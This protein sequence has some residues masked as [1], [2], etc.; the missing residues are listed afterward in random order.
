MRS[1]LK[2]EV[3]FLLLL[4]YSLAAAQHAPVSFKNRSINEGLS[5]SSVVDIAFD[6]KGFVWLATQDGLNRYDG[7]E[8]FILEKK[9][10]DITSGSHSRLGKISTAGDHALWVISKGGY[11][12]KLDLITNKFEAVPIVLDDVAL[13]ITSMLPEE[14]GNIWIGTECGKLIHYESRTRKILTVVKTPATTHPPAVNVIFRDRQR[15]LWLAGSTPGYLQNNS[16]QAAVVVAETAAAPPKFFSTFAEDNSG[17]IWAGTWGQGLFVKQKGSSSFEPFHGYKTGDLPPGL[18]V[19]NLLAD[20]LGQLWVGSYGEGLFLVNDDQKKV[21]QFVADKTNPFSIPFNDVLSVKQDKAGGVWIGTDGGG[22]SYYNEAMNNFVLFGTQ[23]VPPYIDIA[24]IRSVTTD[25]KGTIWVGTSN[26]GLTRLNNAGETY[27]TWTF[28][29]FK[30]N[31]Y[32]PDRIV[33]LFNSDDNMLWLGTQGNGLIVFDPRTEKISRWYN[34]EAAAALRIPDG[35]IWCIYPGQKGDLWLGTGSSGLCLMNRENELIATYAPPDALNKTVDAIRCILALNDSTLCVGFEKT[36]IRLFNTKRSAFAS[37]NAKTLNK[38]LST[39]TTIKSIYHGDPYLYIGT[40]GSGLYVHNMVTGHGRVLT[41]QHGLPNNTIYGILPDNLGFL[42]VSTNRGISR[43]SHRLLLQDPQP[44]HFVNYTV[45]Q[46]LQ[47][48]EFNTGAYHKAPNG[49][50]LF[51]GINGLNVFNPKDF[52]SPRQQTP[53]VFTRILVDN[54]PVKEDSAAPFNQS[55]RLSHENHS[56]AFNFSALDFYAPRQHHYYYKL[57]GYD[58]TW[59]DAEER[60][61]VSYTNIS[62]GRYQFMVTSAL[63]G[64]VDEPG[65]T[66]LFVVITGPFWKS[67][68]FLLLVAAAIFLLLYAVYRSRIA[69]LLKLQQVRQGIATDLHDDIGSTLSNIHILSELSK[70][71]LGVPAQATAF[72]ERI[73][74]EVQSSSQSLDDIIWSVNSH[75]DTWP[76]TFSRMRRYASEVFENSQTAYHL[77]IEENIVSKRLVMEKRRD[78]FLI[79]KEIINNIHRHAAATEVWINM[80]FADHSLLMEIRD[81]GK[82]YDPAEVTHRNGLK[83]LRSRITHWKGNLLIRTGSDGTCVQVTI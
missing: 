58:K 28:P 68:W 70:K 21:Q 24:L 31:I 59:I 6:N 74:E 10:D 65:A 13:G 80:R 23:T 17:R 12:E 27:K 64:T 18:V 78:I 45:V 62:P 38:F 54:E 71:N 79:Y 8:F 7:K 39:G 49:T 40:D 47:S 22:L 73:S 19:E 30:K 46:G 1:Q 5:Q 42:W 57:E 29:S 63:P 66:K 72:L 53:V 4:Q 36:G 60:S 37:L 32:N 20:R 61:Y 50:L 75:N 35:T 44:A 51:G 69:Q 43:L 52:R 77:D 25:K 2:G 15:R 26:K 48:N 83:N 3:L 76:E 16:I 41:T 33:S 56:F 11:L 14:D 9:F 81:N 55:I 34:P 67:L 82:G